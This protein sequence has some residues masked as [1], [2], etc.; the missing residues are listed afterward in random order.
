MPDSSRCE[1][2]VDVT[3]AIGAATGARSSRRRLASTGLDDIFGIDL[4]GAGTDSEGATDNKAASLRKERK[5]AA[6]QPC[7]K[8]NKA[9]TAVPAQR[10]KSGKMAAKEALPVEAPVVKPFP[11]RLTGSV[12]LTWRS[13][14][15]E[16][17]AQFASRIGVSAGCISQWEKKLRQALQVRERA[18]DA[19]KKTWAD[20]H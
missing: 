14:L 12:I 17:Q 19:L 5:A 8:R 11:R 16:T 20:T 2:M 13:S 15:G 6:V 1:E 18:L 7:P 4:A 10:A 9:K 3:S